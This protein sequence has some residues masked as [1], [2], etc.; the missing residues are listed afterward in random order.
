MCHLATWV[1]DRKLNEN[2]GKL[3]KNWYSLPVFS[4]TIWLMI[5]CQGVQSHEKATRYRNNCTFCPF[6]RHSEWPLTY[7]QTRHTYQISYPYKWGK[8]FLPSRIRSHCNC[9]LT[10]MPKM[11]KDVRQGYSNLSIPRIEQD[12]DMV[13]TANLFDQMSVASISWTWKIEI[14][15]ETR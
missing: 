6:Q 8:P 11:P 14:F 3:F 7:T 5:L 12:T 4:C 2:H 10:R 1:I 13:A 15:D 9:H